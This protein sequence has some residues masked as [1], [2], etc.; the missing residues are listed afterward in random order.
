MTVNGIKPTRGEKAFDAANTVL[1]LVV[2]A[3]T[4]Y[5]FLYVLSSSVSN[6]TAVIQNKVWLF[7]V[8]FSSKAY[9]G[10]IA[11]PG[12]LRAYGMTVFY[13][14]FG[15]VINMVLT[16]CAAYPLS[17]KRFHGRKMFSMLIVFTML[18]SGGLIPS[19]LCVKELG[20]ID[21]VWA[22][23]IPNAINS[24]NMI[25]MRSFFISLPDELEEAARIDGCG[26]VRMLTSIILP[27]SMASLATV[28]LFYI[29]AHWNSYFQA[30]IYLPSAKKLRP[31]QL[32]LREI[33]LQNQTDNAMTNSNAGNSL[34]LSETIKYATIILAS[35]PII[36]VYPFIQKYFVS[37]VMLG[38]VKG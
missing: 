18:F 22:L 21:T 35:A 20:F 33:L 23:L 1:M 13:A 38:A 2:A 14:L 34:G 15:T 32:I 7:P 36:C 31:L 8:G 29:V 24:W 25:I 4:L 17:R 10:V 9:K 30:L 5:P 12:L 16:I 19:Y 11:Y 6:E 26:N 37:G 28:S 27:V 3:I